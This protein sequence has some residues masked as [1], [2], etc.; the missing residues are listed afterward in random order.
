L[1]RRIVPILLFVAFSGLSIAAAQTDTGSR[2]EAIQSAKRSNSAFGAAMST[3]NS[4]FD[5][6]A[7]NRR[8]QR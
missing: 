3:G 4:Y 6:F 5:V 7:Q 1:S 2:T 8:T